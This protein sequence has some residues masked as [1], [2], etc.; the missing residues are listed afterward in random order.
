M[1]HQPPVRRTAI[2]QR[3]IAPDI[4]RGLTLLGI[5]LAN[6]STAWVAHPNAE[7][8]KSLGGVYEGSALDQITVVLGT[9]F[10]HVRG[11]PMFSTLLGFGIGMIVVSLSRRQYPLGSARWVIIRRYGVLALF[12]VV[13]TIFLFFGDIMFFYGL[14]GIVLA[15]LITLRD[16]TLLWLAGVIQMLVLVSMSLSAFFLAISPESAAMFGASGGLFAPPESYGEVLGNG[17]MMVGIVGVG[18]F[19]QAFLFMPLMIFGFVLARRGILTDVRAHAKLLWT[20]VGVGVAVILLIGLPWG[21]AEIGVLP[22]RLAPALQMLNTG[23]GL[24]TGPAI[25]AAIALASQPLQ[26]RHNAARAAGKSPVLSLPVRALKA[27]GQRSMSGYLLQ[28][29][30][31]LILVLPFTL[32]LGEGEGAFVL[33]LIAFG[34]WFATLVIALLLDLAG[35]PGPVEY[36]HRLLSYGRRGLQDPWQPKPLNVEAGPPGPLAVKEEELEQ[37]TLMSGEVQDCLPAPPRSG[38]SGRR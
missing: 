4:A 36:L 7:L 6:V 21:L 9:M 33:S 15:L 28:S 35:K 30:F 31:F 19:F 1:P 20:M 17:A 38:F 3:L 29:V 25:I 32:N 8:A 26:D 34:V 16:K 37:G 14:C 22:T 18:F 10:V 23:F 27:L 11:L 5:A 24:L 12:G 2:R 13:H